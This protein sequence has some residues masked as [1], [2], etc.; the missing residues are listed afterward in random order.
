PAFTELVEH[1]VAHDVAITSTLTVVERSAPGR[2]PPPQGA[3]DA[4]LPQLRDNVTARLARP[5][6]PGGDG[7][8]LLAKYMAMEKAFYDA[9]GTLVVGTDPT[10]GGDVVPGYANQRAVQLLVEIGLTIEQAIEV[11]TRNGAAYLERDH[12]VG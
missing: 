1:L 9:G 11:A 6:G 12:D 3:L 5:A 2:P 8:A 4:M 7:G 10:G